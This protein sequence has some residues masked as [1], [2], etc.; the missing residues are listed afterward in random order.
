MPVRR[1][2]ALQ[3]DADQVLRGQ[4]ADPAVI[5][6][7]SPNL[8]ALAERAITEGSTLLKPELLYRRS[9]VKRVL[10]EHIQLEGGD[11]LRG[12]LLVQHL[13]PADEVIVI[14]CSIG[15]DLEERVSAVMETDMVYA[16]ALDG[17]GSAGVEALANAGCHSLELEARE[18]GLETSIPLS[19]GMVDWP[20]EDGQPQIFHLLPAEE[21][22]VT[23]TPSRAMIPRKSLSMVIGIGAHMMAGCPCDYCSMCGTC[24]Y[25]DHHA[26]R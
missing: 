13:A 16:L 10:H 8:V 14:L 17:F 7:R 19:P 15:T 20:V 4:G 1:T 9:R 12:K 3:I 6:K 25:R 5:R 24:R 2:W 21:I 26:Q 22:G 23:M 18:R 11:E